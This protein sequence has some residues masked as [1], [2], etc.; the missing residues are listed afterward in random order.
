MLLL[1]GIVLMQDQSRRIAL[2][3]ILLCYREMVRVKLQSRTKMQ[4]IAVLK[5]CPTQT[6]L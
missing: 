1:N 6:F 4:D 2:N 5:K 3:V